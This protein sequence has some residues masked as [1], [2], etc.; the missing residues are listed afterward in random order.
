ML[1]RMIKILIKNGKT[2]RLRE[3]IEVFKNANKI[4]EIEY[5]ELIL[6]LTEIGAN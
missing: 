3:K 1:Y 2:D 6:M 4:S 5:N